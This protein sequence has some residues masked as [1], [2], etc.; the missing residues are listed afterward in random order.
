VDGLALID[1]DPFPER[2]Q[3][4]HRRRAPDNAKKGQQRTQFLGPHIAE[5]LGNKS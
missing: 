5:D 2:Q 4:D 3:Q 1:M